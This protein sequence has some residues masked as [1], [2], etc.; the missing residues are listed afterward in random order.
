MSWGYSM[1][2]IQKKCIMPD[3]KSNQQSMGLKNGRKK[4]SAFCG[5]HR[6]G[7]GKKIRQEYIKLSDN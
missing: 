6:K 5:H 1:G 2:R 3:C 7:T 4:Y